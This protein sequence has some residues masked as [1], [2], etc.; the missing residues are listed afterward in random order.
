MWATMESANPSVFTDANEKGVDRVINSRHK[1][2]FF[3]ESSS[4]EYQIN[5]KCGLKQIGGLLDS[6]FYGIAV[7]I[8]K[9]VLV[10]RY[11][12]PL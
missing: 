10:I 5:S 7:P 6:K 12:V 11:L 2:A 8:G 9:F 1:Y 4:I 3:M